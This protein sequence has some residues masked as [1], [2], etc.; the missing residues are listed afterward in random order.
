MKRLLFLI[1]IGCIVG[2]LLCYASPYIAPQYWYIPQF[3]GLFYSYFLLANII[4]FIFWSLFKRSYAKYSFVV[5][6]L[7]F[8]FISRVYKWNE[9]RLG[10][11]QDVVKMLTYN[12]KRFGTDAQGKTVNPSNLFEF[13]QKQ[14]A[15]IACF[16]E[17]SHSRYQKYGSKLLR[18]QYSHIYYSGDVATFSKYPII[19][20]QPITF[21]KGH[22]VAGIVTDI[23]VERDTLR[24]VNVHLESNKLS[25]ANKKDIENLVSKKRN[26]QKLRSVVSKLKNASLRRTKQVERLVPLIAGSPYPVILCGD[27]NDTPLSYSYQRVKKLLN[28]SFVVAG[29]NS[30]RTFAEGSIKVRIDYIFSKLPFYEHTIHQI[31]SSDHKPVTVFVDLSLE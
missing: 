13:V 12:V 5:I 27:F 24:V 2:L 16:Q 18:K 9:K 28:D 23:V 3:L 11:K 8:G 15:E 26:F 4:F 25:M 21:E 17:Y 1:N 29:K 30:G 14:D 6:L 22:Y 10:D 19:N 7:G 31:E 20:Q